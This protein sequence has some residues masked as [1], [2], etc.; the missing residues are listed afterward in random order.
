MTNRLVSLG[1]LATFMFGVLVS[2]VQ[3]AIPELYTNENFFTSE[4]DA[5]VSFTQDSLGNFS[6][7]TV[8]G[9]VFT[10]SKVVADL[11]VHLHYFT[12]EQAHFYISSLGIIEADSDTVALSIYL[13]MVG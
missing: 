1:V 10:Q 8:S 9:K 2:P 3:A 12:I 7:L 4:H 11:A 6:G 13:A 5:P